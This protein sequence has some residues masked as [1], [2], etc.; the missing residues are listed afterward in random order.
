MSGANENITRLTDH[1]F[2]TEAGKLVAILTKIFG[3]ANLETAEDVVQETLLHALNVWKLKGVPDNPSAWLFRVAKNK[4]IDV[5]RRNKHSVNFDFEGPKKILLKSEYTIVNAM[6]NLLSEETI[7]DDLLGMMFACC[8]PE[9]SAENQITI[10]LKTLCGFSTSEISRAF[11]TSDDVVS[12]RLYR[13]KEFFRQNKIELEIPEGEQLN[14]RIG[15]VLNSIYLLFSEGY[16]STHSEQLIRTELMEQALML[17]KLL[18]EN[19]HTQRPESFALMAL[20]CFHHSRT[21]SRLTAE[22]EIIL[23]AKQDRTLWNQN[24]ISLGN[25]YM[26]KAA[27]GE[28]ISTYHL[29]AAIAFEHCT[30][31][32]FEKTNWQRIH[33]YY[34]WLLKIQPT[35]IVRLNKA[36]V[37]LWLRGAKEAI[38]EIE[39]INDKK[40]ESYYL[41]HSLHGE[42]L[43]QLG[44]Q[45]QAIASYRK[46]FALTNS[47][48]EKNL[49]QQ[50]M[51]MLEN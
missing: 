1:L 19:K 22:G 21:E 15:A 14:T 34:E 32:S 10:I 35:S 13:T 39:S 28:I 40:L 31:E 45:S 24:S 38:A 6:E 25:E 4:A 11:L 47:A 42:I 18:T 50:K 9:I 37:V 8:H 29:E 33:D 36:A 51:G 46:A 41:F 23:L 16:N 48:K 30:S 27:F 2:R 7:E 49:I 20:M 26:D 43:S 44:N 3:T 17:C 12:K 5:V